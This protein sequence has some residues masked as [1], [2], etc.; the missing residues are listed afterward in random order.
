MP[1]HDWTK[2]F[3]GAFHHFHQTWVVAI[4]RTLNAGL[5]PDGYYAAAEQ[6]VGGP[7]ADVVTLDA[8]QPVAANG[9]GERL[10]DYMSGGVALA[11]HP[12]KVKY[13]FETERRHYAGKADHIA[14]RHVSSHRLIAVIEIISPG[15]KNNN[16]A[17]ESLRKK[18]NLLLD[19]G[20]HLLLVDMLPPGPVDPHGLPLALSITDQSEVPSA[21]DAEPF[22]LF[23]VRCAAAGDILSGFVELVSREQT[24][25]DMPLFLN[26]ERYISVPLESTYQDAWQGVPAPWK[27]MIDAQSR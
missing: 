26:E 2:I 4:S 20:V 16:R 7:N 1:V 3:D 14:L 10:P 11:D 27:K 17:L 5:L 6:V 13:Q 19:E 23:S 8:W 24:L 9:Q 12:P 15:N 18:V 25:P 22:T 21:T